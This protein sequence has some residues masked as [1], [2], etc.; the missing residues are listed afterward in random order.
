MSI[1]NNTIF[2]DVFRTMLE[3]MPELVI[4]LINEV[5]GTDYPKDTP[6]IQKKNEHET[7]SGE[8]ITDSHL[9]IGNRIYHLE[10]QSTGDTRMVIRMIEYDFAIALENASRE[11]G[12]FRIIFPHSCV[13]YLRGKSGAEELEMEILMPDERIVEYRVPVIRAEEYTRNEIFQKN[14]LFLL[15]FYVIRYEK[16]LKKLEESTEELEKLLEEYRGIEKC[17]EESLLNQGREEIYRDLID[18]IIRIADYI[19][20]KTETIRKG[21]G[22]IMGG[23]VLEL[24][25]ERLIQQGIEQGIELGEEK[26][27]Y[28]IARAMLEDGELSLEKISCLTGLNM[29]ELEK[30]QGEEK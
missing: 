1:S 21:V 4:P 11:N 5:F 24:P 6:I 17:L 30:I 13:L 14:L 27:S 10:C 7:K 29:E 9:F 15:P 12:R 19:F 23:R 25:S 22:E 18:L 28:R 16:Q 3:K 2:D 26:Q 20:R 8:I